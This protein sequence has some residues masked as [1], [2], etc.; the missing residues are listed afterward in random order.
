M[1]K[2]TLTESLDAFA[3]TLKAERTTAFWHTLPEDV[4]QVIVDS[5]HAT[6]TIVKWLQA[7]GYPDAT[8]SKIEHYRRTGKG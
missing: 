5:P 1:T 6:H 4:R 8:Y 2:P 7:N 3:E